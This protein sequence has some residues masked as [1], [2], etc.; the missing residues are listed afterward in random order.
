MVGV[1]PSGALPLN[2]SSIVM[3]GAAGSTF[4]AGNICY[5]K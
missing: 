1:S 3:N 2:S 5:G 4:G